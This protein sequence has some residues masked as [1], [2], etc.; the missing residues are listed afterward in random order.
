MTRCKSGSSQ[1]I[2]SLSLPTLLVL[3]PLIL[4]LFILTLLAGACAAPSVPTPSV[5]TTSVPAD[6]IFQ[7]GT[8]LTLAK[9]GD[10]VEALAVRDGQIVATG[11]L[12]S[13]KALRGPE[14]ESVDLGGRTLMPG[15]V[16][17]HSHFTAYVAMVDVVNV[18]SPPAGPMRNH[19]EIVETL[20]A[21]IQ[22]NSIPP[23]TTVLGWGY[24]DS[25][26]EERTH[27]DRDAL[28]RASTEH[29][30]VI[31]HVS[32]HLAAANSAGLELFGYS[33]ETPDP[34]GGVIRRREGSNEPNGVL[35]ETA[36]QR[37]F[38]SLAEGDFET[39]IDQLVRGQQRVLAEGITTVQ[40]GA[41][42]PGSYALIAEAARRGLLEID[43]VAL[44]MWNFYD[45][46]AAENEI[47]LEYTNHF[48][49]GGVK[50]H[51]DGSPQ[52]KTAYFRDPYVIPPAGQ[53]PDYRGYPVVPAEVVDATFIKFADLG[54]PV[55][56][57][58]NGDASA[59]IF[60]GALEKA[61]GGRDPI[62]ATFVMIHAP[63]A[64]EE[65]LDAMK[66]YG[67]V[68]SFFTSHVFYWGDY[69]RDSVM[70]PERAAHLSPTR[71]AQDRELLFNLHTDTPIVAYDQ[72]HLVW[73]AVARKTRSGQVLGPDQR[74]SVY[75]ALRAMTYNSA[76]A[77]GEQDRKGTLEPGKLADMILIS[78]NP[79]SVDVDEL[80][81]IDVLATWKEG[82]L[83]YG[84]P[85]AAPDG[86]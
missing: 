61:M 27:P 34:P 74:L 41:T 31:A 4:T 80:Q 68:P 78:D 57:H 29:P 50:M 65:H 40:D 46:I 12:G 53:G 15:F 72:F 11:T 62:P 44:P 51:L 19:D 17:G 16:D 71:W 81:N 48:K 73:C 22:D 18:S 37:M 67:A 32:G 39:K 36:A 20:A 33:A 56:A 83:V 10:S 52:G 79:F 63:L 86:A 28:D 42:A 2:S 70:G 77:Y 8:I 55:F 9:E 49:V 54:L 7:G 5:P 60:V 23:G 26:L 47:P 13:M 69:H 82:A 21:H 85:A 3:T 59:D 24:D 64:L 38:L 25:L 76:Y 43:V 1:L 30:I 6:T 75:E 14:T 84:S 66:V 58:A 35:E 45:E